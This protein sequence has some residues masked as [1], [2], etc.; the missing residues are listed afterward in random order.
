MKLKASFAD[1]GKGLTGSV[2]EMVHTTLLQDADAYSS[3]LVKFNNAKDT[4]TA[5]HGNIVREA[6]L[7]N[8]WQDACT[9]IAARTQDHIEDMLTCEC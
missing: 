9:A 5:A 3:V 6:V 8:F 1:V 4:A 7:S 2:G